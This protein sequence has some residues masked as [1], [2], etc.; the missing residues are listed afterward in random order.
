MATR[1]RR[2][3]WLCLALLFM[4]S[5]GLRLGAQVPLPPALRDAR[6]AYLQ[7]GPGLESKHLQ[8]AAKEIL[9][10]KPRQFELV[11]DAA[12]ADIILALSFEQTHRGTMALPFAGLGVIAVPVTEDVYTLTV[13]P[14]S[15]W[16]RSMNWTDNS[17]QAAAARVAVAVKAASWP[18]PIL[19]TDTDTQS[20]DTIKRFLKHVAASRKQ[21]PLTFRLDEIDP[22]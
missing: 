10:F 21:A 14:A 1:D 6:T 15:W 8:N 20:G 22:N 7:A 12:D 5:L 13:R 2:R 4:V 18:L 16:P 3:D 9:K 17:S 11:A 19:W